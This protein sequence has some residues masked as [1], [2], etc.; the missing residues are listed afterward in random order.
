M[1]AIRHHSVSP[2]KDQIY[3]RSLRGSH[4]KHSLAHVLNDDGDR[5]ERGGLPPVSALL[6]YNPSPPTTPTTATSRFRV[7][8][9]STSPHLSPSLDMYPP[10]SPSLCATPVQGNL[11]SFSSHFQDLV[12]ARDE[13][14]T[15]PPKDRGSHRLGLPTAGSSS[16]AKESETLQVDDTRPSGPM[17]C[18]LP[19]CDWSKSP[20]RPDLWCQ[21]LNDHLKSTQLHEDG[22]ATCMWGGCVKNV[23]GKYWVKHVRNHEGYFWIKC[24]VEDCRLKYLSTPPLV[25]HLVNCHS[26]ASKRASGDGACR[27][28]VTEGTS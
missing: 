1:P 11:P 14:N 19:G 7:R 12:I 6:S 8:P 21:H 18:K 13:G 20:C 4:Y 26:V 5:P 24:P 10:V 3:S 15:S 17:E 2:R 27:V 9:P 16:K 22:C 23:K 25:E 28:W